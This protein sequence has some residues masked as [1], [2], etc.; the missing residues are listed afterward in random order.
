MGKDA[1]IRDI[2]MG[3][4]LIE[5]DEIPEL[6]KVG[7][8]TNLDLSL[9]TENEMVRLKIKITSQNDRGA[10]YKFIDLTLENQQAIEYCFHKNGVKP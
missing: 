3:G 10:G 1:V 5:L 4:H 7:Q 9:P 8:V 2:S 6:L